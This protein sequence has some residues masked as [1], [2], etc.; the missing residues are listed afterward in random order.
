MKVLSN[1]RIV[2]VRTFHPGNIGSV[3][4][5]MKTMGLSELYL[6]S[7]K[8]FPSPEANK[9]AAGAE[10]LLGQIQVVEDLSTA[11][12]GCTFIAATS[13]RP[14]GYDLPVISPTETAEQLVAHASNSSVAL[15]FGP[16]R[17]GLHN[18]DIKLAKYRVSI[19]ANPNYRSLN[20]AS[21][22]Q[23]MSYEIHKAYLAIQSKPTDSLSATVK[24]RDLPP[25][26]DIERL[27]THLEEVLHE[28]NFLRPHQGE[29]LQRL[30]NLLH[31]AEP[32]L[33]ETNILR[34]ILS[35]MQKFKLNSV[36][37]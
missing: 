23:I 26:E 24:T 15:V 31:R 33:V 11:L 14:R 27:L 35:A 34:G 3:A 18:H 13:A 29:T 36:R 21:A 4:R 12:S 17:M 8:S 30:R 2:L 7:P 1:I 20:L 32:D 9:M 19:P 37:D 22:V 6:V 5:A 25:A 16:E 10:D 28:I